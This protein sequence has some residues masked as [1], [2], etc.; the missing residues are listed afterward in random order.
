MQGLLAGLVT[1][2]VGLGRDIITS[3]RQR[4][5]LLSQQAAQAAAAQ[6]QARSNAQTSQML[7]YAMVAIVAVILITKKK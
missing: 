4:D 2:L 6:S 3:D 1:P 5:I 7:I